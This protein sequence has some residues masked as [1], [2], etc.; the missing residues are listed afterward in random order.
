MKIRNKKTGDIFPTTIPEYQEKIVSK[1]LSWKYDIV[2][3]EKPI[4]LKQLSV[5]VLKK[6]QSAKNK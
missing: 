1:G 4:E 3:D 2:E 6:K 5:E